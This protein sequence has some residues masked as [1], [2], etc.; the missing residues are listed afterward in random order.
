[1][2]IKRS[3]LRLV[4]SFDRNNFL[5]LCTLSALIRHLRQLPQT[6]SPFF[7][8]TRRSLQ[9]GTVCFLFF[10]SLCCLAISYDA[11]ELFQRVEFPFFCFGGDRLQLLRVSSPTTPF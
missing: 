9:V 7:F 3:A 10:H 2:R 5:Q 4:E 6:T 1:M 11:N 8:S